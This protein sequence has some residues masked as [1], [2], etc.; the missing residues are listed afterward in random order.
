MYGK[1]ASAN[2]VFITLSIDTHHKLLLPGNLECPSK[3]VT[4][5]PCG[6]VVIL[7]LV[8]FPL[9]VAYTMCSAVEWC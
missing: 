8:N 7:G 5:T 1:T 9:D 4:H 3:P 6:S 2:L